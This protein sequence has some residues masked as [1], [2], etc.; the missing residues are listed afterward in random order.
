MLLQRA[1]RPNW[2]F[3]WSTH[4]R[5][6]VYKTKTNLYRL[7]LKPSGSLDFRV[8]RRVGNTWVNKNDTVK[9]TKLFKQDPFAVYLGNS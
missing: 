1:N 4:Y 7:R 6:Y 3:K 5:C 8:E 2:Q 9:P